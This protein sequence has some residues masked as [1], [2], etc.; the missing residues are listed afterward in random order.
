MAIRGARKAIMNDV[1]EFGLDP[2]KAY[3]TIRSNGK[4]KVHFHPHVEA[5][6]VVA[7]PSPEPPKLAE[8]T[9]VKAVPLPSVPPVTVAATEPV[10]PIETAKPVSVQEK[11]TVVV[12]K[13]EETQDSKVHASE[14]DGSDH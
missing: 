6:V 12:S 7:T 4:L 2:T 5:P 11:P 13:K 8:P 10:K 14:S 1:V 3:T 9:P